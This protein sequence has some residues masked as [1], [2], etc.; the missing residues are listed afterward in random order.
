MSSSIEP[1]AIVGMAATVPGARDLPAFLTNLKAGL[2]CVREVPPAR[3]DPVFFDPRASACDRVYCRRGGFLPDDLAIDATSFGIMPRAAETAEPDQLLALDVAARA[4]QDAGWDASEL[5]GKRVGVILGRG[6]YLTPGLARFEQS[7]RMPEQLAACLRS[8][9]PSL[10][11]A[12]LHELGA[13]LRRHLQTHNVEASIGLVPNLAASRITNRFD[14]RGPA[15]TVDAACASALVAVD[16]GVRELAT[17]RCEL[18]VVGGIHVCHDITFWSVFSQ[19]GALSRRQE[20]RPFDRGADGLLIGEG[21]AMLVLKRLKDA[22]R[23]DDRVYAIIRGTAVASD[24]RGSTLMSPRVDGQVEA[25]ERAWNEAGL[26]PSSIGYLEAHGTAT[27]AGDAAELETLARAFGN[28]QAARAHAGLGSVKSMIGHAMPA[29]GAIGLVK[30]ALSLHHETLF[31]T[32]HCDDP[33]PDCARTRFRPITTLEPWPDDLPR[34]AGVNAFGFGGINAHVVLDAISGTPSK[35]KLARTSVHVA[36]LWCAAA[37][38]HAQLLAQLERRRPGGTGSWRVAILSPTAERIER[39]RAIVQRTKPWRG[40]DDIW[41]ACEGLLQDGK[42]A[43]LCP[44]VEGDFAPDP[45]DLAHHFDIAMPPSIEGS[46][47]ERESVGVIGL[48]RMLSD[49]LHRIAVRPHAIAGHSIGEWSG[50][51]ISG[52][53]RADT[54]EAFLERVPG[55]VQVPD[56]AFAALGCSAERARVV[57]AELP[58]LEISH[59]N[60]P[61]QTIV[62]G[63]ERDIETALLRFQKHGVLGQKL[64]F[65]SGFHASVFEPFLEPYRAAWAELE[66]GPTAIPLWSATTC[67]RYPSDGEQIRQLAALHLVRPVRFRELIEGLHEQGVRG[68]VQLGVGSLVGFVE[69]TLRGRP[70]IAVSSAANRTSGLLQLCRAAA[71]LWVEGLPVALESLPMVEDADHTVRMML[72]SPL[73]QLDGIAPISLANAAIHAPGAVVPVQPSSSDVV[74]RQLAAVLDEVASTQIELLQA[75][76]ERPAATVATSPR[77]L[78]QRRSYS[79]EAFPELADH[80]FYRQPPGW[81]NMTDRYPVVP[82]TMLVEQMI[83]IARELVPERTPVAIEDIRAMRWLAVAPPVT[84]DVHATFDGSDRVV[85]RFDGYAEGIV[86]VSNGFADAPAPSITLPDRVAPTVTAERVYEDRWMFHGPLYQGVVDIDAFS[87]HGV[88]GHLRALSAPGALLDN[89]GQLLGLWVMTRVAVDHM[90]FPTRIRSIQFFAPPPDTDTVLGCAVRIVE[91]SDTHVTAD[92]ELVKDGVVWAS[93]TGWEDTRFD[94]DETLWRVLLF[95]EH[96]VLAERLEDIYVVREHWRAASARDLVARRYL[97]ER[98]RSEYD[99]LGPRRKRGWLLGRIAVKDAVR[100]WLW[101]K[102]VG[103][104]YPLEI[105]VGNDP[106]GRPWV[107]VPDGTDLTVSLAHKDELALCKVSAEV[108]VGVDIERI[109]ARPQSFAEL[110]FTASELEWAGTDERDE[111]LMRLWTAKEATGK[112]LGTGIG[113][114]RR[115]EMIEVTGERLLIRHLDRRGPDMWIH[116]MRRDDY[117][118]AWTSD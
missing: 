49:V 105:A 12:Q 107:R 27:P 78:T 99:A 97:G 93:I 84:V 114:P 75:W 8:L 37:D 89:A 16:H 86:R 39:A 5:A 55:S 6:G 10:G 118:L 58:D 30:A 51:M 32:L 83:G 98:E 28:V 24:G 64:A 57:I 38:S 88:A 19:L 53:M 45:S 11:D 23:D 113:D 22:M 56:V 34:R 61:H 72:G 112:A 3:W 92:M 80:T 25:V 15:Y 52:V 108:P 110:A 90:A 26:E 14:W 33:H 7:V 50:M 70:H 103:A 101:Q 71:A 46:T 17:M 77:T 111:R 41:F 117:I 42:L 63:L 62:C 81:T 48:A 68:F 36:K 87:P 60:C 43:F 31:P 1:V 47:L 100:S 116:T 21:V 67:S 44:G 82:M 79:L 91:L 106:D 65:R 76:K 85:V 2:D 18:V 115:F 94:S 35:R 13:A 54:L 102:R 95:P 74:Q 59:D 73:L 96:N 40:R 109:E 29:A 9:L 104:V 66:F 20:I 4:V 69:D